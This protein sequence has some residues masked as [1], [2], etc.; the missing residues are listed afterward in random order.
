MITQ[1]T[2][3]SQIKINIYMETLSYYAY[4][5]MKKLASLILQ[6]TSEIRLILRLI[7]LTTIS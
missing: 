1:H 7:E 5:N 4:A 2:K 6:A 3:K